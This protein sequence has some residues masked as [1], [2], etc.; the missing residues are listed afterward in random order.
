M[1]DVVTS[2]DFS[3]SGNLGPCLLTPGGQCT[4]TVSFS[5]QKAG[6]IKGSVTLE[7]Y[8]ECNPFPLHQCSDPIVLN[9][10]GTGQQ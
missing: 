7:T 6:V 10:I 9:L 3:E 1:L 8:P 4:I 2:G 5:P